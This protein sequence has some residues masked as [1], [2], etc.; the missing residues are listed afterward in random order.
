[1]AKTKNVVSSARGRGAATVK[2]P[3]PV[4]FAIGCAALAAVLIGIIAF[5]ATNQGLGDT[6]SLK[7]AQSSVDGLISTSGLSRKHV[8]T[9]VNYP[10]QATSPPV[11]GEHNTVP[12]SCQVYTAAIADEHAV[13]S[14]EHGAVW[15]TYNPEVV[16]GAQVDTLK[17][18]VDGN[19]YRMLSPYPGL[20]SPVSLQAWG[21]Q[22]MVKTVTDSRIQEFVDLFTNG[23]QTQEV[24][25]PCV[26]TTQ[27][28]PLKTTTAV[29]PPAAAPPAAPNPAASK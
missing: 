1:M 10:G 9:A 14:L 25:S 22:L 29:A 21:E 5:A 12:Q 23:P 17:K 27:T 2:K 8:D 3:F 13:H 19:P 11:G 4:G 20:K 7:Y 6:K 26:G 16:K 18:L 28:G 24:G 15:I